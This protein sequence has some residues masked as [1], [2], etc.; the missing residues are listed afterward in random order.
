MRKTVTHN[1]SVKNDVDAYINNFAKNSG[2]S[3]SSS[4]CFLIKKIMNGDVLIEKD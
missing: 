4:L 2:L 1:V 3:Y